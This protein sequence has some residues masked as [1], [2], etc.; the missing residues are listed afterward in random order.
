MDVLHSLA[1]KMC[2]TGNEATNKL[3]SANYPEAKTIGKEFVDR[4]YK[5]TIEWG[6]TNITLIY[7]YMTQT[8]TVAQ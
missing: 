7:D 2:A 8:A 1:K 3:I 6:D 4:K 5:R